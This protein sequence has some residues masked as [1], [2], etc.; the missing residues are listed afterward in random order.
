MTTDERIENATFLTG[1]DRPVDY[2][3]VTVSPTEEISFEII[4]F[5]NAGRIIAKVTT[6]FEMFMIHAFAAPRMTDFEDVRKVYLVRNDLS[7][8][9]WEAPMPKRDSLAYAEFTGHLGLLDIL[10]PLPY[11]SLTPT[12]MGKY[13]EFGE[14]TK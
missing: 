9:H 13:I 6:I 1:R 12:Q 7:R 10:E 2:Y 5:D 4:S 3:G 14:F 11:Q 8:G